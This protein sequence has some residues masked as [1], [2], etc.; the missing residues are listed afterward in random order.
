MEHLG[1]CQLGSQYR[2][3]HDGVPQDF[4]ERASKE[5]IRRM[6]NKQNNWR[7]IK[8]R[9]KIA[10]FQHPANQMGGICMKEYIREHISALVHM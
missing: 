6:D 1:R 8:D 10:T 3:F 9:V 5:E 4:Y 7:K 2:P